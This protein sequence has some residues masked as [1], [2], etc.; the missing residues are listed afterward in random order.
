MADLL[1]SDERRQL[2]ALARD[3]GA[4][5]L[6]GRVQGAVL[7]LEWTEDCGH[8]VSP[9]ET[10]AGGFQLIE[11]LGSASGK[12]PLIAWNN[13]GIRVQFHVRAMA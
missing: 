2:L 1:S 12:S 3:G 11:R 7:T 9:A 13:E 10:G 6:S 4:V 8:P 5:R